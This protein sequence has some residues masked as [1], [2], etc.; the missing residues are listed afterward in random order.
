MKD[1]GE[2][3]I[4]IDLKEII[5]NGVLDSSGSGQGPIINF[6]QHSKVPSEFIKG[7]CIRT[8]L[9]RIRGPHP[10]SVAYRPQ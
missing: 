3:N 1:L 9:S 2:N 7:C 4:K 5:R 8:A 6:Y 10:V